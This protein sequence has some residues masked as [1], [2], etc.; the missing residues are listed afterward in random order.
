M[1]LKVFMQRLLPTNHNFCDL[2]ALRDFLPA[3]ISVQQAKKAKKHM[4]LR[5]DKTESSS[6]EMYSDISGFGGG[7]YWCVPCSPCGG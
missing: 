5:F 2:E 4:N 1:N 3:L 7:P 6:L